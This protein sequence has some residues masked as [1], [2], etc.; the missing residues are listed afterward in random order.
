LISGMKGHDFPS[1]LLIGLPIYADRLEGP[2]QT[3]SHLAPK[4]Y[5]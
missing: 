4:E 3:S 5:G 2:S 1:Q